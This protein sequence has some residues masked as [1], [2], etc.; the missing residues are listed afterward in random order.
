MEFS[1]QILLTWIA[2]QGMVQRPTY[3]FPT[4]Y[5]TT[6]YQVVARQTDTDGSTGAYDL[7]ITSKTVSSFMYLMSWA[8][9]GGGGWVSQPALFGIAI[10]Y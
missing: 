9:Q 7:R 3:N 6:N 10:G 1:N 2:F 4:A 5:T 8:G